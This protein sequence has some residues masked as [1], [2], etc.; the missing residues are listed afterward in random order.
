[1]NLGL[2]TSF[3]IAGLLMITIV[4]LNTRT[5]Q[6]S[7][8]ITL[9]TMSQGHVSVISDIIQHDF[10]KIGYNYTGPIQDAI[11]VAD[12]KEIRF[13]SNLTDD[14]SGTTQTVIWRL[15]EDQM[16]NSSNP[17]HRTLTRIV[18]G[19]ENEITLGVSKFELFY[20]TGDSEVPL[21]FP[22][23]PDRRE[24]ISRIKVILEVQ[25]KEGTG[26]NNNYTTSTWR[27]VFTPPNLNLN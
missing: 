8:D 27:K 12:E 16:Q 19:E 25:P 14:P 23:S 9:H 10:N 15:S 3:I 17:R 11:E 24:D 21:T 13:S 26:R 1:M 22:I 2:V 20:Y 4:T 6:H 18:D 5:G 7:A